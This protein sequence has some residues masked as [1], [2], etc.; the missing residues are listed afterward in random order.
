M[1]TLGLALVICKNPKTG[2]Y[3]GVFQCNQT[4][5]VPGGRVDAPESFSTGAIRECIEEAGVDID[6]KGILRIEQSPS[7]KF[8]RLKS[9]NISIQ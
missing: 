8:N 7:F 3:L 9:K 2:K 4:W 5:W 1:P 6:I